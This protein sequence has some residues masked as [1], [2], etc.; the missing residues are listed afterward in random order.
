M[1]SMAEERGEDASSVQ[2]YRGLSAEPER[3]AKKCKGGRKLIYATLEQRKQRNRDAQAA[4]RERRTEHIAELEKTVEE[5]KVKLQASQAAHTSSKDECL[6]LRYKNSLLERILLERGIDVNEELNKKF[7]YQNDVSITQIKEK[8]RARSLDTR[9]HYPGPNRSV[10]TLP[11][12]PP[13]T[14][15]CCSHC[16]SHDGPSPQSQ[17]S[18][19]SNEPSPRFERQAVSPDIEVPHALSSNYEIT[20]KRRRYNPPA[21]SGCYKRRATGMMQK[22][23]SY[24]PLPCLETAFT[25]GK[26][27]PSSTYQ[28]LKNFLILG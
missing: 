22:Y 14:S 18:P 19:L 15:P 7:D 10:P 17:M 26:S 23:S 6:L 21:T 5:Q 8:P 27:I 20:N 28:N 3:P 9:K 2:E 13:T 11:T 12:S 24:Q 25:F 4:F 1:H 16:N